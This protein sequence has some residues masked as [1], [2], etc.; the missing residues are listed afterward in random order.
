MVRDRLPLKAWI[1]VLVLG[2]TLRLPFLDMKP[3]H[4]DEG[5]NGWFLD[6]M[7][8][9]QVYTYDH[10]NYHGPLHFYLTLPF[11]A[12]LGHNETALRLPPVLFSM[13]TAA[14]L[15]A[16]A[17]VIGRLPSLV[18]ACFFAV[19]PGSV[20]YSRYGIHEA[21]LCFFI[22]LFALA[23]ARLYISGR[24]KWL[25]LVLVSVAGGVLTKETFFIN[26]MPLP[27]ALLTVW[28]LTKLDPW[29]ITPALP[30]PQPPSWKWSFFWPVF[31][32]LV[33]AIEL[34]YSGFGNIG[35]S[36]IIEFL[37]S[38]NVW[39]ETGSE[40]AGH[41]KPAYDI[42]WGFFNYYWFALA[43]QYEWPYILA[44]IA[45]PFCWRKTSSSGRVLL[46]WSLGTVT[47]YSIIPYKTP[48]CI[49]SMLPAMSLATG[50]ILPELFAGI[51][52]H[53]YRLAFP[54]LIA[55][56]P[57]PYSV[58]LNYFRYDDP[59]E[60]YVYVQTSRQAKQ[61][62]EELELARL[63]DPR[64]LNLRG[65]IYLN[66]Y[67]PLPWW[68]WAYTKTEYVGEN[69]ITNCE[70][71][72]WALVSWRKVGEFLQKNNERKW[73]SFKFKLRDAQDE[74]V[75]LF[76]EEVFPSKGEFIHPEGVG[77]SDTKRP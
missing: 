12:A 33:V 26:M 56:S 62:L 11:V 74:V 27:M 49:L 51:K 58:M 15:L 60:K 2:A 59:A 36:G 39:S 6:R 55:L 64:V 21:S 45:S 50:V 67:Y 8:E 24:P 41:A 73:R 52:N 72:Y 7:E 14:I 54:L 40:G 70:G 9:T 43:A 47:A 19:S 10:K 34:I 37:K 76:D 30:P 29:K 18:A 48:W 3:A 77:A 69:S 1:A 61:F 22:A 23:C 66:S 71:R 57:L 5:V 17:P 38:Y 65:V 68:L 75:A 63:A 35:S 44:I 46:V 13:A 53:F 20:F 31:L 32:A 4:F 25:A 28:G 16:F 42:I